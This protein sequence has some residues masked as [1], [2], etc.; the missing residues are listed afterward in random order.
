MHCTC[1]VGTSRLISSTPGPDV[2]CSV[3]DAGSLLNDS[4]TDSSSRSGR[5]TR[6]LRFRLLSS[7]LLLQLHSQI[8][9]IASPTPAPDPTILAPTPAPGPVDSSSD[10]G[11]YPH[12]SSSHSDASTDAS[13]YVGAFARA[14]VT[15]DAGINACAYAG[16]YMEYNLLS[17][18]NQTCYDH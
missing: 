5:Q 17:T 2:S 11:S 7:R 1:Y 3:F 13:T 9:S 12:D 16:T 18:P 4:G 6:R 14:D 10:S 8:W 15:N